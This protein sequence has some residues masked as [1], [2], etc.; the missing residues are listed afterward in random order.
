V[1]RPVRV[2]GQPVRFA[3]V[4]PGARRP[5]PAIGEHTHEVLRELLGYDVDRV[6][7]LES[8]GAI[9][10]APATPAAAART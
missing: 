6:A 1:E 8:A 4:R 9:V 3:G 10:A 5:P 7:S 2:L